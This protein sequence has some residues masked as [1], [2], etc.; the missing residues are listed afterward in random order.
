MSDTIPKHIEFLLQSPLYK[1]IV[2]GD[3]EIAAKYVSTILYEIEQYDWYCLDCKE[4]SIF[5]VDKDYSKSFWHDPFEICMIFSRCTRKKN[6][7]HMFTLLFEEGDGIYMISK[8]GQFPSIA[9]LAKAE[10]DRYR[11]ILEKLD[12]NKFSEFSRA[13][14]LAAHGIGIG[15]FVYLRRIF[16]ALID[17]SHQKAIKDK[18][19]DESI[20]Q[21]SKMDEKIRLLDNYLPDFLVENRL[22]YRILSMGI[23]ELNEEQ[24]LSF[25]PALKTG[26]EMILDEKIMEAE[27]NE[28]TAKARSE[29]Q[30]IKQSLDGKSGE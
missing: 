4:L 27:K 19:W 18:G 12:K 28:K 23:H 22:I 15:S 29:L 25:F 16:E 8:V 2:F 9:D 3:K 24:C 17:E 5:H 11:K 21:K 10:D 6:H 7:A 14:G 20:Y 30:K 13:V 1:K 26:I